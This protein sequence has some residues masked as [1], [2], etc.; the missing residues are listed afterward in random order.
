MWGGQYGFVK[1]E[2]REESLVIIKSPSLKD[3]NFIDFIYEDARE[4]AKEAGLLSEVELRARLKER[5]LW[6]ESND[7]AIDDLM[8]RIDELE[9]SNFLPGSRQYR[10]T[11]NLIKTYKEALERELESKANFFYS[12]IE[13]FAAD[14]RGNAT[15]YCCT[16]SEE[17]TRLWPSWFSFLKEN[18]TVLIRNIIGQ[19]N[20][21]ELLD[22]VAV[23]KIARSAEW[24]YHWAASKG[25][26]VSLFGKPIRD[27]DVNQRNLTYW[28]QVYDSV[29]E[30]YERPD[31]SII[32]D[33]DALDKWFEEQSKKQ[34]AEQLTKTGKS[35]KIALS[36]QINRHGEI[37]IM[38]NPEMN[39]DS[40]YRQRPQDSIDIQDIEGLNSELV[41]KLKQKE[42]EKIKEQKMVDE[43]SLRNNK[44]SRQLIGS[45]DAV[46][47]KRSFGGTAKGKSQILPGGTLK[48]GQQGGFNG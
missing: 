20:R 39:P 9:S 42:L 26:I 40:Q 48:N 3:R 28:S 5:F 27:F 21:L 1:D 31:D 10:M 37:Y 25:N 30:S 2:N 7:R 23:R 24:R 46:I 47:S 13:Q 19:I 14:A 33:D 38:A 18:D 8:A 34:R 12:T 43:K 44:L 41:K 36:N 16:Y 15:V 22:V 29:Y 35:G 11:Q 32:N 45:K 17:D 6:D 4:K